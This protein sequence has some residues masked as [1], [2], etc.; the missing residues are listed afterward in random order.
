MQAQVLT[1]RGIWRVGM[2][3]HAGDIVARGPW[4]HECLGDHLAGAQSEPGS[5]AECARYW[6]PSDGVAVSKPQREAPRADAVQPV[7]VV[8]FPASQGFALERP[9]ERQLPAVAA[10]VG[11]PAT[12]PVA[13]E[14]ADDSQGGALNVAFALDTLR[15]QLAHAVRREDLAAALSAIAQRLDRLE[16]RA[17]E[18]SPAH[19]LTDPVTAEAWRRKCELLQAP[20]IAAAR[21]QIEGMT[22]DMVRLLRKRDKGGAFTPLEASRVAILDVLDQHISDIDARA[23][24]LMLATPPDITADRHWP[25]LGDMRA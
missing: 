16:A 18:A 19:D 20:T 1:F 10:P 4:S 13:S 14:I 17:G 6:R 5:G 24:E 15:Q 25:Q 8:Q 22:R 7:T 12:M 9:A 23:A 2:Y 3:Y 11:V 21:A